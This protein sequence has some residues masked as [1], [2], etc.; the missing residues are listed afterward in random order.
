MYQGPNQPRKPRIPAPQSPNVD[1][2]DTHASAIPANEPVIEEPPVSS[3]TS[4]AGEEPTPADSSEAPI[5]MDSEDKPKKRGRPAGSKSVPKPTAP[6]KTASR[7]KEDSSSEN[8]PTSRA[9]VYLPE[10]EHFDL[11][12][13][14]VQT[15]TS[16]TDFI[17]GLCL[18]GMHSSYRC[19]NPNC[20]QEF[21]LRDYEG[22]LPKFCP[23][24]GENKFSRP[25]LPR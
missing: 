11:K 6:V 23:V 17:A 20:N 4:L 1:E 7:K 3:R 19:T 13:L 9:S 18:D 24:C 2:L 16:V 25:Y 10:Q 8:L 14:C 15:R 5:P 22:D 12:V 21:V